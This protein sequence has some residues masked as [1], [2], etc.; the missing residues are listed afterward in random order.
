M[1]T[2]C[3][4][5]LG[6]FFLNDR[7][8]LAQFPSGESVVLRYRNWLQPELAHHSFPSNMNMHWLITIEAIEIEPIRSGNIFYG[9]HTGLRP[10]LP[11]YRTGRDVD[12]FGVRL[13]DLGFSRAEPRVFCAARER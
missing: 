7:T 10:S 3:L 13:T 8:N 6:Q 9:G 1:L 2:P 11:Y 12:C 4:L 5:N